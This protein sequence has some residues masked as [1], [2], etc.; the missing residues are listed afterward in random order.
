MRDVRRLIP[1]VVVGLLAPAAGGGPERRAGAG[2]GGQKSIAAKAGGRTGQARAAWAPDIVLTGATAESRAVEARL[3][4]FVRA[5][6]R[7]NGAR[8]V[9]FLSRKTPPRVRAAVARQDWPWRTAP[10]D[11]GPLFARPQLRLR[12]LELRGPRARVRLGPQRVDP[13]S[14]QAVGF[15]DLGMVREG[16]RWQVALPSSVGVGSRL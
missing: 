15:Y 10:H 9:Q 14:F 16:R 2:P 8:A 4:A 7:R 3:A 12:T 1:V 11:I 5:V 6:R 13:D